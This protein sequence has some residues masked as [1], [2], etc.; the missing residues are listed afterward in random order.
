MKD[1]KVENPAMDLRGRTSLR[2]E[3]DQLLAIFTTVSK[4]VKTS[5]APNP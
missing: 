3:T 4:R 5:E 2:D 1:E